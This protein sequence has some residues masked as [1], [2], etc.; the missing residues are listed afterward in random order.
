MNKEEKKM[1]ASIAAIAILLLVIGFIG[2]S[3]CISTVEEKGLKH[4]ITEI[5]EGKNK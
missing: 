2:A 5:W 1:V 3:S 4:Y